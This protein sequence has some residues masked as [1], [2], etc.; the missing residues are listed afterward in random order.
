MHL[1]THG[2]PSHEVCMECY[3]K[4]LQVQGKELWWPADTADISDRWGIYW[5]SGCRPGRPRNAGM[6]ARLTG[7]TK[8]ALIS[9]NWR[10][11]KSHPGRFMAYAV[12]AVCD[13]HSINIIIY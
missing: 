1:L 2:S 6:A 9:D 7:V 5:R 10:L 12:T 13:S 8:I 11:I 4:Q 3:A